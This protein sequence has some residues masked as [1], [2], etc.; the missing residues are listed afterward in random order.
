MKKKTIILMPLL[1]SALITSCG[2]PSTPEKNEFTVTFKNENGE[3]LESKK[4]EEGTIPSY[5]YTKSDTAEWDY[6][7]N[8]W[9]LTQNGSVITIPAVSGDVTYYAV[10]SQVKQ[11]YTITFESN[12]GTKVDSITDDY[13]SIINEPTNPIKE[14]YKFISW[15]KDLS[16][17]QKVNWPVT[18]TKNEKFYAIWNKTVDIKGYLKSLMSVTKQDPYSYIPDTMKPENSANQVN[19]SQVTYDLTSFTNVNSIRYGG[20][21]EQWN[22]VIENIKQ[23]ELFYSV[24]SV[25]ETAINSSVVV[26]N[27][28]LDKNPSDK[29]TH[30]VKETTY[31]AKINFVSNILTY[32]IEY[33]T[34]L[35]IPFFGNLIP[36]VDMKYNITTGEKN[37]KIQLTENNAMKYSVTDNHYVFALQYGVTAVNRKAYFEIEKKQ[38]DT[39]QGHIYEFVQFK[40]KDLIP[41]CAD[42]YIGKTYTSAIGNKASGLIGFTGYINELY[43]TSEGKLLGYKVRETMTIAG[44]TGQ[45]NTLWFNLNNITGISSVKA[46]ENEN[47]TGHYTNKNSHDLYINGKSTIFEPSYNS[48]LFVKTSR[49]FDIELRKQYFYGVIDNK[50]TE[51]ETN[52]PMMFIQDDNDKDTNYSDFSDDILVK[53]GINSRVTLNNIYLNKIREDYNSL[54]DIFIGNKELITSNT[55]EQYINTD[56]I[57]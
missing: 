29:A 32:S 35:N 46:I 43:K 18:I 34:N 38:D 37:V 24:L 31:T 1:L 5:S 55:I 3:V 40:D 13:G 41:S 33:K 49:K 12:G 53:N 26:F 10:V 28:Y 8:G 54:I 27:N 50:L 42:F 39:I 21:G 52:I 56:T 16:G 11:R 25:G 15:A 51:Y 7:V 6:T 30:T 23:S 14:G 45:Y 2:G 57:A 22:M 47:N 20:F 17:N 4:W 36:K 9:S 19:A 44:V 48:K